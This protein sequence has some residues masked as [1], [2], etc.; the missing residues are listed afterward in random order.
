MLNVAKLDM[1]ISQTAL[2]LSPSNVKVILIMIL[3]I[4]ILRFFLVLFLVSEVCEVQNKVRLTQYLSDREGRLE[5]CRD[6]MWGSVCG[7]SVAES[8]T[9]VVCRGLNHAARGLN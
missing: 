4:N 6:G 1:E 9:R 2:K 8:V 3:S 5:I 7:N